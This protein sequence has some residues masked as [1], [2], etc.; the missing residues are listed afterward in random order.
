MIARHALAC[1][2]VLLLL[3]PAPSLAQSIGV[4]GYA[5]F[6]VVQLAAKDTFE[7][8]ADTSQ[9]STFGGGVQVT[10]IWKGTF[11]DLSV[12][13]MSLDGERVFVDNG[14]VFKL[15]IPLEIKMRPIDVAGGWRLNYGRVSPYVGAGATFLNY[16]EST[17]G[18]AATEP[19]SESKAGALVL[20]GVDV[21]LWS[22]VHVG[23]ELRYRHVTGILGEAGASA[24]FG[25]DNAGGLAA[26]VRVSIGR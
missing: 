8:V 1:C 3:A 12:F 25:E 24:E 26:A 17:E 20:G 16:E 10:N 6:G 15:A 5:A 4:R 7:A 19:V 2:F 13:T 11:A 14:E 21:A 23:G 18:D 22:V 9:R